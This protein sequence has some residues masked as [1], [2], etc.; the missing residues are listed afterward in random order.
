MNIF[1]EIKSKSKKDRYFVIKRKYM[2]N[3]IRLIVPIILASFM[4][5]SANPKR[6]NHF[7]VSGD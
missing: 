6:V 5:L 7:W 4:L 2:K 1:R 3:V